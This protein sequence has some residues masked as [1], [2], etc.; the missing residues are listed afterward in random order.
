MA[1]WHRLMPGFIYDVQ[2]EDIVADPRKEIASVLSFCGLEYNEACL[3]FHDTERP[4]V[5]ASASQ[6][7]KPV[8]AGSIQAW[9]RYET[10]LTPLSEALGRS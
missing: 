6:V 3:R 2:Y 9:R 4:V 8:Y 7:R 1:H 5:T 10:Y